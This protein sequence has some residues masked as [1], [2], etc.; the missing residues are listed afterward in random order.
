MQKVLE[1]SRKGLTEVSW[2][3]FQEKV[4]QVPRDGWVVKGRGEVVSR[5][6]HSYSW[7]QAKTLE[8]SRSE[9]TGTD[10]YPL[11]LS[12]SIPLQGRK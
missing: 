9:E 2:K 8:V 6:N 11:Y 10:V 1:E 4:T 3:R 5:H 7:D 12:T